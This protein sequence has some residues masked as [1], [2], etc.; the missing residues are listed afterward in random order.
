MGDSTFDFEPVEVS[1]P[2]CPKCEAGMWVV[3]HGLLGSSERFIAVW[4]RQCRPSFFVEIPLTV[5]VAV[6]EQGEVIV[7]QRPDIHLDPEGVE[8]VGYWLAK[9]LALQ[10][11][12]SEPAAPLR[13]VGHL[14][15]VDGGG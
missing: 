2:S 14:V 3:W 12:R 10:K 4:C 9:S 11:R 6:G 5:C 13:R 7:W 1:P 15:V 8:T